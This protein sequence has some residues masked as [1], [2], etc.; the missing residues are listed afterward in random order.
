MKWILLLSFCVV[1]MFAR[2]TH[3]EATPSNIANVKQ[4]VDIRTEFE[5]QE[6][7]LIE[8]AV[9][10]VFTK[11]QD[12]FYKDKFIDELKQHID[13]TKPFALICRTGRRSG[14]VA[15]WIDS[16]QFDIT[17]FSG[18]INELIKNGYKITQ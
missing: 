10:V 12:K 16:D 6:T 8:G 7:G 1:S 15:E 3:V 4:L 5:I 18:G 17:H 13:I 9:N 11:E 2:I 14:K